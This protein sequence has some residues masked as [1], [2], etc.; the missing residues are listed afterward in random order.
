ML[1]QTCTFISSSKC[2]FFYFN[3][4]LFLQ[5][6]GFHVE[7]MSSNEEL[8]RCKKFKKSLLSEALHEAGSDDV[9]Y[10]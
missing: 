1:L 4:Y 6:Q 3:F 8:D 2:I 10:S 7:F 5:K 9:E